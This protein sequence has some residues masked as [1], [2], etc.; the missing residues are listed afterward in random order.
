M[1][2]RYFDAVKGSI[3]IDGINLKDLDLEYYRR[4]LGIVTQDI[5]IFN[6]TIESNIKYGD[7]TASARRIV[8]AA[9]IANA[10]EFIRKLTKKYQSIV[11]ERGIKLSGGQKQ[12]I[13]IARAVLV[14]PKILILDEATSSLDAESEEMIKQAINT[15]IKNR[16][17]IIVAH[18]LSTIQHADRI[19]VIDKGRIVEQGTHKALLRQ[20]GTYARLIKLQIGGYLSS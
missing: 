12:R 5:D 6:D 13:G 4:Q 3:L 10:D 15:V 18:R 8:E 2:Y 16:T 19:V 17:T 7:Q 14:D 9:K 11:G 1:L 20:N